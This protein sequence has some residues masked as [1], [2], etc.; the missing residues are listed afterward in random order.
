[1]KK[2]TALFLVLSALALAACGGGGDDT[3]AATGGETTAA[4]GGGGGG[5]G[6][7]GE[8][9]KLSADPSGAFKYNTDQLS[10]KAG[11]VTIDFDNPAAVSHDVTIEKDGSEVAASDLVAAGSTSVTAQLKPGEYTYY[12]SVPGHREGGMEGTL[13]VK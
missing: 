2:A 11:P 12:C 3:T 13:T 5:G 10:A 9:L 8:T 1:M 6:G 4:Q 7:G